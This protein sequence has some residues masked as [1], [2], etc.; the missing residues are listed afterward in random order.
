[1]KSEHNNMETT[2]DIVDPYYGTK[3]PV[4]FVLLGQSCFQ[5][6]REPFMLHV[7]A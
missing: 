5:V 3:S 6:D 1:M 4:S 2:L 7:Q